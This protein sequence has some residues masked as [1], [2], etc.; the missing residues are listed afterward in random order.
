MFQLNECYITMT[1]FTAVGQQFCMCPYPIICINLQYSV[2]SYS[3]TVSQIFTIA[4]TV[5][6]VHISSMLIML[7]VHMLI[8]NKTALQINDH[9][10]PMQCHSNKTLSNTCTILTPHSILLETEKRV[11]HFIP[12]HFLQ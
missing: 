7:I 4:C 9:R 12:L 5:R 10:E 6:M 8:A 1:D 2:Y 3:I 11:I